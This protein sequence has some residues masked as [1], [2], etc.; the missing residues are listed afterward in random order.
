MLL[1]ERFRPL[2][3]TVESKLRRIARNLTNA[4]LSLAIV[5][6]LQTPAVLAAAKWAEGR[7]IGILAWIDLPRWAEIAIALLLLDY[8]LWVW[9]WAN[10]VVPFLW[11][12]HL[13]H[14][15]DRDL[16]AS[17]AFR[18]HFGEMALSVFY[19]VAQVLLIGPDLFAVWMWQ[20]VLFASILFHHSNVRLPIPFERW[21]VWLFVTPR[22]HG[23]HH[24][25]M[26]NETNSNWSSL[27]TVWDVLHGTLRLDVPQAAVT[28]GVPAYDEPRDV[29]IGRL[30]T[31]P[32]RRQ[33][34]DWRGS[35]G[36]V[37]LRRPFGDST[38][39]AD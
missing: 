12:F 37:N 23:I 21:L 26:L 13:V 31:M 18:F 33:R 35:D 2:R 10:H 16:D 7:H 1:A 32:F 24:S 6:F 11:R 38:L 39:L 19:R 30:L 17:T 4:G 14:H 8:T 36:E 20:T 25:T 28:I 34:P 15:V 22:M 27:F 9:H 5:T 29:T 3:R